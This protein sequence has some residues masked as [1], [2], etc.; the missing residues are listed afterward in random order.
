MKKKG[1]LVATGHIGFQLDAVVRGAIFNPARPEGL[2]F[3]AGP[4]FNLCFS[5]KPADDDPHGFG[6]TGL[7]YLVRAEIPTSPDVLA[8]VRSLIAGRYA[9][10]G[11]P[12][13]SLP[14]IV[15]DRTL[16]A[17]DGIIH[18]GFSLRRELCPLEVQ[19]LL[20]QAESILEAAR[21]RFLSLLRWRQGALAADKLVQ[22]S[23]IYWRV[24]PGPAYLVP[25]ELS[26]KRRGRTTG[27]GFRWGEERA[28]A[29]SELW[30]RQVD[31]PLAHEMIREAQT[32]LAQSPRSALLIAISA[33]ET[34]LKQHLSKVAPATAWLLEHS[35]S[36]PI[37]KILRDYVPRLNAEAG[38]DVTF[39]EALNPKIKAVQKMV[40]ARNTLAHTGRMPEGFDV[41][42]TIETVRDLLY[43]LDVV[44]GEEWAKLLVD[45][46]LADALGWPP[47]EVQD[48]DWMLEMSNPV[49]EA[50]RGLLISP[51]PTSQPL[52]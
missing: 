32:L 6:D 52:Q 21:D 44:E 22:H 20:R 19:D 28:I 42:L 43:V 24:E 10:F 13:I 51:A 49:D 29:L 30:D 45:Q 47:R 38:R 8:F 33:A 18:S 48:R 35:P 23:S 40:E 37:F 11:D 16:I 3:E 26:G 41:E 36:P 5:L 4:P 14:L 39:W 34:G 1:D 25:S 2:R 17:A 15:D 7:E 12:A 50:I 27:K 9:P 46:S 31:E